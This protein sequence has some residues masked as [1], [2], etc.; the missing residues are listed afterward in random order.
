MSRHD[1]CKKAE[2]NYKFLQLLNL[3]SRQFSR[4]FVR[5]REEDE[6][7]NYHNF[8]LLIHTEEKTHI[9]HSDLVS[10]RSRI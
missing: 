10:E 2:K 8:N 1:V 7:L 6:L 3:H 5:K 9:L 4:V